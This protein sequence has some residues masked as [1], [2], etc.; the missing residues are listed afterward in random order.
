MIVEHNPSDRDF[1]SLFFMNWQSLIP[2]WT[3][4]Q[5]YLYLI[6]KKESV[7][8]IQDEKMPRVVLMIWRNRTGQYW[9]SIGCGEDITVNMESEEKCLEMLKKLE[10]AINCHRRKITYLSCLQGQVMKR[11]RDFTGKKMTMLLKITPYSQSYA[12]FLI[13]LFDF[14]EKYNKIKYST[15]TIPFFIQTKNLWNLWNWARTFSDVKY[16][17]I[18]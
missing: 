15:L 5:I 4:V 2:S 16:R 14:S 7:K 11:L 17:C 8:S 1:V 10:D 6:I 18:F 13:R 12:Y 9:D 3:L